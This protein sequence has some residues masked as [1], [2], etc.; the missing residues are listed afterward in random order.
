MAN[1]KPQPVAAVIYGQGP[2]W[3]MPWGGQWTSLGMKRLVGRLRALGID[4]Y[5][6]NFSPLNPVESWLCKCQKEGHPTLVYSYSL[7]NTTALYLTYLV[8]LDLLFCVALS[9]LA[10][11]NNR[12]I[13]KAN[14]KRSCL[15]YGPGLLSDVILPGFDEKRYVDKPHLLLDLDS[16]V[17]AWALQ[18]A[19]RFF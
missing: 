6:F 1:S 18:E 2:I 15:A 9:S 11:K 17:S 14:V 5:G 16:S 19:K 10:G 4:A 13:Y 12:P 3:D 7:G 8:K